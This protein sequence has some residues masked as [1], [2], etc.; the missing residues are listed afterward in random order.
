MAPC[1]EK[2][3]CQRGQ[4]GKQ[5]FKLKTCTVIHELLSLSFNIKRVKRNKIAIC[6]FFEKHQA[7]LHDPIC[8]SIFDN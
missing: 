8:I 1:L 7:C 4:E 2:C 5:L 3:L 6:V